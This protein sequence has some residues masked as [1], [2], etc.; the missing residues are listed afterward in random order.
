[1]RACDLVRRPWHQQHPRLYAQSH[2][3]SLQNIETNGVALALDC[4][5]VSPIDSGQICKSF[6][7]EATLDAKHLEIFR[8]DIPQDHPAVLKPLSTF[9]PRS[10]L[11]KGGA[12]RLLMGGFLSTVAIY[13]RPS[14]MT[15]L[16]TEPCRLTARRRSFL[17][18]DSA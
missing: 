11:C 17:R 4:T 2:R 9:S 15:C 12:S 3:Q 1:M 8:Q 6:L 14:E 10:I 7:R 18:G 13:D 16:A 5:D